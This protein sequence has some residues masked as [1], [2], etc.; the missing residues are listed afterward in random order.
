VAPSRTC[1]D[2]SRP[3][4]I[5]EDVTEK[6][7]SAGYRHV[8]WALVLEG[9]IANADT[10]IDS[11]AAYKNERQGVSAIQ[12]AGLQRSDVF[13]TTK[14]PPKAVGYD[15]AKQSIEGSLEKAQVDY[16]DL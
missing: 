6:A 4:E 13:L 16:F 14:V 12:K 10:Q 11:A 15:A 9:S 1:T 2:R 8:G 7:L 3:W 5:A